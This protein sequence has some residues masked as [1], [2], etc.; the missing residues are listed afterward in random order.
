MATLSVIIPVYNGA[1]TLERALASLPKNRSEIEVIAVD[2]AS[3]DNSRDILADWATRLPIRVV[4]GAASKAWTTTTNLGFEAASSPHLAML[5]QD[6]AWAPD[7]LD[8]ALKSAETW[9]EASLWL[10]GGAYVDDND[11]AVGVFSPPFG[12]PARL[13]PREEALNTLIVQNT[14]SLPSAIFR[15][16]AALAGGGLDPALWYTAD[17]DLWLRLA[18]LGPVGW[19]PAK[20][21]NFRLHKGSQT[22]QGSRNA[23]D[24]AEQ[25]EEP[26]RRHG[27]D[28]TNPERLALAKASNRMN[29]A[30]AST[31][32]GERVKWGA[33]L[34]SLVKLGPLGLILFLRYT[35]LPQRIWPRLRLRLG[36]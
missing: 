20:I 24:F 11:R 7:F 21:S 22:M 8:A 17:W 29:V 30:L 4:D 10:H 16:D 35:R 13:L 2:Q 27:A 1:K 33:I 25:L 32:H 28:C 34:F 19:N 9:P 15:R 14:T 18:K 23:A 36:L 3:S 12:A 26:L 31:Y 6:D 5:H